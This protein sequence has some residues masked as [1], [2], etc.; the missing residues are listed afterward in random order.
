VTFIPKPSKLLYA[1]AKAYRP[2]RL[3]SFLSKTMGKLVDRHITECALKI[4][5]LKRNQHAYQIGKSTETAIHSVV[6]A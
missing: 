4:H 2:I 3:S 1:E 5:S 6:T